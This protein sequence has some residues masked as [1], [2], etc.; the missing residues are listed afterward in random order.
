MKLEVNGNE[1]EIISEADTP[2]CGCCATRWVLWAPSMDVVLRNVAL[3]GA[4]GR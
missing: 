3:T 4:F 1:V 2:C